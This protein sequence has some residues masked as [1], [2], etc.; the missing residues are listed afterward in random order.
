MG[1]SFIE[2]FEDFD[3][4]PRSNGIAITLGVVMMS[5][6]L[7]L[8]FMGKRIFRVLL[9]IQ[10]FFI[11]AIITLVIIM[12]N[13]SWFDLTT[14]KFVG[15]CFGCA[16]VGILGAVAAYFLY[17]VGI[18]IMGFFSGGYIGTFIM[19]SAHVDKTWAIILVACIFGVIIGTIFVWLS[20]IMIVI[21]TSF[22]GS[23]Y[24]ILG[25]DQIAN[26]G[27]TDFVSFVNGDDE[28]IV[29]TGSLWGM[30]AG[31][32]LVAIVGCIFQFIFHK[33]RTEERRQR[34]ADKEAYTEANTEEKA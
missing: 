16:A 33:N 30:I 4:S 7:L 29:F 8:T 26:K 18:F 12:F 23:N 27:F 28:P 24:F 22:N 20:H 14:G 21:G 10:A 6:G 31:F 25:V 17:K 3:N 11:F 34:K 2:Y 19:K 13:V 9:A 15:I 32:V 5:F 1:F